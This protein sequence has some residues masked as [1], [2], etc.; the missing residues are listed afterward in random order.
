MKIV[1]E[2]LKKVILYSI[3]SIILTTLLASLFSFFKDINWIQT[4]FNSNYIVSSIIIAVGVL[5]FFVP[6]SLK[7]LKKS[8]RLVDHSNIADILREEKEIKL[9]ESLINI[10]WGICHM[11]IVGVLEIIIKGI[12]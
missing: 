2:N 9:S 5:G 6:T 10:Y 12:L 3:G 8:K 1:I 7:S 4:V 11:I